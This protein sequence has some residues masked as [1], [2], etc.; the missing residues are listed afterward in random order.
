MWCFHLS[1]ELILSSVRL[2][3]GSF[4]REDEIIPERSEDPIT[5]KASVWKDSESI[6]ISNLPITDMSVRD[7][8]YICHT[9]SWK[10]RSH[11]KLDP[12]RALQGTIDPGIKS[13]GF[14][15]SNGLRRLPGRSQPDRR[16]PTLGP[17]SALLFGWEKFILVS[18]LAASLPCS[19]TT[20]LGVHAHLSVQLWVPYTSHGLGNTCQQRCQSTRHSNLWRLSA[21]LS[22]K[23]SVAFILRHICIYVG[24]VCPC[25]R[26]LQTKTGALQTC[27]I[28]IAIRKSNESLITKSAMWGL[29][30]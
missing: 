23:T 25:L 27:R 22:V 7:L 19:R 18:T 16:Y 12:A 29:L 6:D 13:E 28:K 15:S 2:A 4:G 5:P 26:G 24:L 10:I 20:L 1:W 8:H 21:K 17:L 11:S 9:P 30:A 3:V 14:S